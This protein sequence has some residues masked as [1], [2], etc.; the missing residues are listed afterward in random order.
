MKTCFLSISYKNRIN[1]QEEVAV[2]ETV[3]NDFGITLLV[4]V[5]KYHFKAGEE[6]EMMQTACAEI[7][8]ATI[9]IAEVTEKAIGVGIEVGFAAAHQ[10]PVIYLRQEAAEYSTTVGGISDYQIVY[11]DTEDLIQKLR[12]IFSIF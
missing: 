10:K 9:L 1:L 7:Q 12:Q 2:I 8:T 3:L 5:D 11:A 6:K 4:F